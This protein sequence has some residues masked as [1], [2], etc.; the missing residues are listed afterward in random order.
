MKRSLSDMWLTKQSMI[1]TTALRFIK[2]P[3]IVRESQSGFISER[4][5][6]A[7][8]L[9]QWYSRSGAQDDID[10]EWRNVEAV[11]E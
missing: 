3:Q 11:N 2:K 6:Y 1:P 7:N 5:T 4:T 8:I 10:G 9:Q